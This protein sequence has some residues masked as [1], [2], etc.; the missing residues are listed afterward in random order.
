[1]QAVEE[2]LVLA[3]NFYESNPQIVHSI[4]SWNW[5]INY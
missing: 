1:M 3:C 2:Q 4:S 5:I